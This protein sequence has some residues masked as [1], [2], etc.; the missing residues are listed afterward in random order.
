MIKQDWLDRLTLKEI[1]NAIKK[2]KQTP[3]N[4]KF[5]FMSIE[6]AQIK[7]EDIKY[8]V[9][10]YEEVDFFLVDLFHQIKKKLTLCLFLQ[11]AERIMQTMPTKDLFVVNDPE[12]ELVRHI[13]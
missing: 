3:Q 13:L 4:S 7:C 5:F 1:Q 9:L 8:N 11:N 12:L 2:E 6:F 10:Y